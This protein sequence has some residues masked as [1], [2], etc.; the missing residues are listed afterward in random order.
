[1]VLQRDK[2]GGD[3]VETDANQ[4]VGEAWALVE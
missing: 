4:A 3:D 1:M 2:E